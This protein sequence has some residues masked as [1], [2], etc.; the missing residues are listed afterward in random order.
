MLMKIY[1]EDR[2][3]FFQGC[4]GIAS[5][6]NSQVSRAIDRL[7]QLEHTRCSLTDDLLSLSGRPRRQPVER[8]PRSHSDG[9]VRRVHQGQEIEEIAQR[10]VLLRGVDGER[11]AAEDD[12]E[13]RRGRSRRG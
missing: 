5:P 10:A 13:R 7:A 12:D 8:R 3:I 4:D 6:V 9:E 2:I 1:N 11:D